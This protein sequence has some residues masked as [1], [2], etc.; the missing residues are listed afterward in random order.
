MY[1]LQR[2]YCIEKARASSSWV[3]YVHSNQGW[4][5][6]FDRQLSNVKVFSREVTVIRIEATALVSRVSWSPE[7]RSDIVYYHTMATLW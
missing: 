3:L 5:L 2:E 7:R 4:Q 1:I 6:F